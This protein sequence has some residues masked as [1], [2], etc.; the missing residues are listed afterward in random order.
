MI[1]MVSHNNDINF[2][3]ENFFLYSKLNAL[4]SPKAN[5]VKND[6]LVAKKKKIF[7]TKSLYTKQRVHYGVTTQTPYL[8]YIKHFYGSTGS[9][10]LSRCVILYNIN[11]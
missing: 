7:Y 1:Q 11:K 5:V 3:D 2:N 8:V 9:L 10:K 4:N 6:P